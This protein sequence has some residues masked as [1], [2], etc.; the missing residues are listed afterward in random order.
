MTGKGNVTIQLSNP[1]SI[2]PGK[3]MTFF[4]KLSTATGWAYVQAFAQDGAGKNYRR[5]QYGYPASMTLP[6]EWNSFVVK[7]PSDF[8]ASGSRI[9]IS[10]D[11]NGSNAIKMYV[12]AISFDD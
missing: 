10:I 12:D 11:P 7:V 2:K 1:A 4:L 3:N 6:G 5:T 8:A 9:G